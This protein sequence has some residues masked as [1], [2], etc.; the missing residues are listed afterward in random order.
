MIERVAEAGHDAPIDGRVEPGDEQPAGPDGQRAV[1]HRRSGRDEIGCYTPS[2]AVRRFTKSVEKPAPEEP[3]TGRC[4]A[5]SRQAEPAPP[6]TDQIERAPERCP[7]SPPAAV[8][9]L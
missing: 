9:T 8:T 4:S 3:P 7:F 5:S 6:P 2:L 1:S